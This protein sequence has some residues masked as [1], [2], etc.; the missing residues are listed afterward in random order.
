MAGLVAKGKKEAGK[1]V[2]VDPGKELAA[3]YPRADELTLQI[4]TRMDLL[5]RTRREAWYPDDATQSPMHWLQQLFAE[6][7][8]GRHPDFTMPAR[9]EVIL[10]DPILASHALTLKIVDTKGIDQVATREDL[11]S[12]FDDQRTLVVLCTR[13]NDSPDVNTQTLLQRARRVKARDIEAKTLILVLPRPDEALAVKHPGGTK[14]EDD[15]EGYL[16]KQEQIDLRLEGLNFAGLEVVFFNAKEE[17]P[18]SPQA[19]LVEKIAKYRQRYAV[20]VADVSRAV[21]HL[22]ENQKKEEV[23]LIFEEVGRKLWTWIDKNRVIDWDSF[24]I[25]QSLVEAIGSTR[26]ASTIRASVNRQGDWPNLDYYHHLGWGAR[27]VAVEVIGEKIAQ[28]KIVVQNQID[29][30]EL[31]PAREFLERLLKSLDA[32]VGEGYRNIQYVGREA[33]KDGLR[34]DRGFWNRLQRRWGGGSGYRE[35]IRDWTDEQLQSEYDDA[36]ELVRHRTEEEWQGLV[37]LL[38]RMLKEQGA[39][40]AVATKGP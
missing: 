13:F 6:V 37:N 14:V 18:A 32:A 26:Y 9:I 19:C 34:T 31:A 16:L 15:Q 8:N 38:E 2:T 1:R 3:Q 36:R 39:R 35:D 7:N 25:E 11:E 22:I 29:D 27:V 10:P 28:F 12:L 17:D 30:A 20:Q 33:F 24:P 40:P 5:R 23:R 21:D 4:L